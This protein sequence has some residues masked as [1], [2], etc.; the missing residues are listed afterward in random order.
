M[1]YFGLRF[2]FSPVSRQKLDKALQALQRAAELNDTDFF[3]EFQIG[4][5]Y[6]YG[7]DDDDN[8][9]DLARAK[10]HLLDAARY[11]KGEAAIDASF[12]RL[13]A[14]ACLHASI[15]SYASIDA[16]IQNEQRVDLLR[17]EERR[18]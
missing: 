2:T 17:S 8:V 9:V 5:L 7:I 12:L 6:L 1:Q 13:A 15:A 4:K 18:V 16:S 10:R 14:Q 11:A 3:I